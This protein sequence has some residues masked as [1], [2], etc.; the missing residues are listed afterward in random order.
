MTLAYE[1]DSAR[2]PGRD[3]RG[4]PDH[5]EI[6][7]TLPEFTPYQDDGCE[8]S[9]SCLECP[10][11]RCKHDDPDWYRRMRLNSRDA[12]VL[13]AQRRDGKS[14]AQ[15][16]RQFGVSLRTVQRIMR[17]ARASPPVS[18]SPGQK[19]RENRRDG[20]HPRRPP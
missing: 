8:V 11:P 1:E 14:P 15:L 3:R 12:R 16:A 7:D 9:P 6:A 17:R 4:G 20:G 19:R 10:L 5:G 18:S 13:E 2:E